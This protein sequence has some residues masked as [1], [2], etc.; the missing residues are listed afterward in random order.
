MSTPML[1]NDDD[2]VRLGVKMPD[3]TVCSPSPWDQGKITR[4]NVSY[5]MISYLTYVVF[6]QGESGTE[7]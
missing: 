2:G 6:S 5:A 1:E 3:I 4:E 7:L